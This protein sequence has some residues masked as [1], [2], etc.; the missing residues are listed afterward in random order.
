MSTGEI[1]MF[2][3][4]NRTPKRCCELYA[5]QRSPLLS[6]SR[7]KIAALENEHRISSIRPVTNRELRPP[8]GARRY[9]GNCQEVYGEADGNYVNPS[10][11][12]FFMTI[13]SRPVLY[14]KLRRRSSQTSHTMRSIR[15]CRAVPKPVLP[16]GGGKSFW[17]VD[18]LEG[19]ADNVKGPNLW[20]SCQ[21]VFQD[22]QYLWVTH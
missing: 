16:T 10:T 7:S 19:R 18:F 21:N 3:S 15:C 5:R 17:E 2:T 6:P 20:S 9:V 11:G 8:G 13:T 12:D 22:L 4:E 1:G 14:C